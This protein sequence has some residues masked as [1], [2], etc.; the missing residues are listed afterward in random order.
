MHSEEF[1]IVEHMKKFSFW[2]DLLIFF[3]S[4][5]LASLTLSAPYDVLLLCAAGS[6][7]GMVKQ[8]LYQKD[9]RFQPDVISWK[10]QRVFAILQLL[11]LAGGTWYAIQVTEGSRFMGLL[12]CYVMSEGF[13]GF[14]DFVRQWTMRPTQIE[15]PTPLHPINPTRPSPIIPKVPI[16]DASGTITVPARDDS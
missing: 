16:M 3:A 6:I 1:S 7:A 4:F 10:A 15:D 8:G 12:I 14:L 5:G 9:P 13:A 2:G 11:F